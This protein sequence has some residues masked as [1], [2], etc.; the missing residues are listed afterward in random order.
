MLWIVIG[1]VVAAVLVGIIVV[2]ARGAKGP[3][4]GTCMRCKKPIYG[5]LQ[6]LVGEPA[7]RFDRA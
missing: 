7:K 4:Y 2:A 6:K 5:Q 1:L 3:S